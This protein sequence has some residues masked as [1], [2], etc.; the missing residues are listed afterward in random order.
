MSDVKEKDVIDDKDDY[1]FDAF[2][3]GANS[4]VSGRSDKKE[5]VE[6]DHNVKQ[7]EE[8]PESN[9][10]ESK[11]SEDSGDDVYGDDGFDDY[12]DEDFEPDWN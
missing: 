8:R 9:E 12:D 7:E 2:F 1:D 6:I 11:K 5:K 10:E 3:S 4:P